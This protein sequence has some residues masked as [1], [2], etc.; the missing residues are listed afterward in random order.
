MR[1]AFAGGQINFVIADGLDL[2]RH[3]PKEELAEGFGG[4]RDMEGMMLVARRDSGIK[5]VRDL[6]GKRVLLQTGS[7]I[8][9]MLLDTACLRQFRKTCAQAGVILNGEGRSH[10]VVLQLFFGKADAAL[11]RSH[12]YQTATELNPQI[13]DRL[14]V[15]ERY[16]VYPSALGMFSSRVSPAFRAY[17][18]TKASQLKDYPRGRQI[19]EVM[20]TPE[21]G[22]YPK[23]IL[24]P[25]R[26][27]MR[28]HESLSA[29]HG[30][31]KAGQ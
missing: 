27:L 23:T 24:D 2:L 25:I 9:V 15:R 20:Q 16:A 28:E 6:P 3:F 8:S 14:E 7:E 12:S 29:R 1:S 26:D 18:I 17:A 22:H 11:V 21:L 4:T 30:A 31:R 10:Q 5:D 13:R 19:L